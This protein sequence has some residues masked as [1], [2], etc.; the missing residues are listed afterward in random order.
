MLATLRLTGASFFFVDASAPWVAEAPE[1]DAFAPIL[2]PEDQQLISYHIVTRGPVW[3][4]LAGEEA[5][6]LEAGDLLLVPHGDPYVLSS[7]PGLRS[8]DPVGEIRAFFLEMAAG[9]LPAVVRHDGGGAER[10][11][12]VCGF[13]GCD[14]RPFNPALATLPRVVH[15]RRSPEAADRLDSLVD[16]VLAEAAAKSSGGQCM[17]LR[18]GELL[19]VEV[20]RRYLVTLPN[21]ETG[22]LA[23]LKDEVVGHA[24]TLLHQRPAET[25]TVESLGREVGLSRSALAERFTRLVGQPPM[26]Y[27]ARWRLQLA[28]NMLL[29]GTPKVYAVATAV[30]YESEAAFSRAFKQMIGTAPAAWRRRARL[31]PKAVPLR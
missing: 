19:F 26:Q 25:W 11:G 14:G 24:L 6:R 31:Q 5:V 3:A 23:A 17:L 30:G 15:L 10:L 18:L 7:A 4:G 16:L 28:A 9:R 29:D 12:V 2:L 21:E 8:A 1:A 22:W 13:L 20:V 27:L